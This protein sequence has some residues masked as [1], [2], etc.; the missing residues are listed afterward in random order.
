MP[1]GDVR[2]TRRPRRGTCGFA[3]RCLAAV[4]AGRWARPPGHPAG[5][6]TTPRRRLPRWARSLALVRAAADAALSAAHRLDAHAERL[7]GPVS[8]S[9]RCARSRTSSSGRR[10]TAGR[11][12]P[13]LQMQIMIGGPDV[14]AIVA[15]VEAGEASRRTRHSVLLEELADDA[16]ATARVLADSCAAVGGRGRSG[17]AGPRRRLPRRAA[18]GLGR[19]RTRPP[20]PRAGG[21]LTAGPPSE[22]AEAACREAVASPGSTRVR[23]RVPRGT[24]ARKG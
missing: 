14:R 10:G 11:P 19:S 23:Q 15:E 13:D 8:R 7:L 6:G 18:P 12:V 21:R 5:S 1:S 9:R 4:D 20:R 17:D 16:A 22:K 2:R 24:R 3:G